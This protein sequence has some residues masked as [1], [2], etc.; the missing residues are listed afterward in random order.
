MNS[1][2][3]LSLLA[4][5]SIALFV[6]PSNAQASPWTMPK[7]DLLFSLNYDFQF[8]EREF[9]PDGTFQK[10]PLNGRF[11]S[12]TLRLGGR[13]GFTSRFELAADV[14][15]KAVNYT[16]DPVILAL[17]SDQANLDEARS[18]VVDFSTSQ[19]GAGDIYLTGRYNLLNGTVA[20][21][22][23]VR[24]KFPT[25]Y[26]P[27]QGTFDED[28]GA[29]ADDI[30][31]GDGQTDLEEALLFGVF[32]PSTRTF[33]RA[34]AGFRLRF[35]APGH[36]AFGSLKVG[37]F[38]GDHI[39]LFAGSSGAYTVVDGDPIGQSFIS[40]ESDLQ[41]EDV[42]LGENVVPVDLPLDKD[43]VSVEGGLLF[44]A[45]PGLELQAS[46]SQ[47]LVGTNIPA[48]QTVSF[49]TAVR[50]SELTANAE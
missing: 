42:V 8:A 20:L 23:E 36:Q 43:W 10:F 30:A 40:T 39:V 4:A 38:L 45:K 5:F 3:R 28:T 18:S 7:D 9:L 2:C 41:P 17:P 11:T 16:A 46:Y 24:A 29:V 13:Y 48:I 34:D 15:F 37:Q 1:S 50:F 27:P 33:G 44:I 31:L 6:L 19:L 49:G 47:I 25:G 14:F 22:N 32:I 35:G 12:S 21:T 26:T